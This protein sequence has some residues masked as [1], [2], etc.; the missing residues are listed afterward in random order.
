MPIA[1]TQLPATRITIFVQGCLRE[2]M[3]AETMATM[4]NK[5]AMIPISPR[6]LCKSASV[7]RSMKDLHRTQ[8]A[9]AFPGIH[10]V[11]RRLSLE[12]DIH[13]PNG[14]FDHYYIRMAMPN[15]SPLREP[16]NRA[17]DRNHNARVFQP[18]IAQ[19]ALLSLSLA[20]RC[21]TICN[22]FGEH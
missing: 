5:V 18:S 4:T 10:A 1:A 22:R 19:N 11:V 6:T 16:I 3:N 9:T 2:T 13:V 20:Y 12:I 15:G 21:S 7:R 8:G 17:A 14:T